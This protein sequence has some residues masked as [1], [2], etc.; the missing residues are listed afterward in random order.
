M[1]S[2]QPVMTRPP[3]LALALALAL[4][5]CSETAT[6]DPADADIDDDIGS[7]DKDRTPDAAPDDDADP[8]VD[9]DTAP[10]EDV[11]VDAGFAID[12]PAPIDTPRDVPVVI[13]VPPPPRD[14]PPPPRDV[15]PPPRDVP[16][17]PPV[18]PMTG[19]L[20]DGTRPMPCADPALFSAANAEGTYYAYCTGM[21]HVWTTSD[22]A[23]FDDRRAATRF[24]LDGMPANGRALGSWWAPGIVYAPDLRR[25]VMWVSVPDARARHT[26]D[27]WDTRSL[28]VLT[29]ATPTGPWDYRNLGLAATANG[30]HFIDPFLFRDRD[31]RRYVFF[32]R[33]GGGVSSSIMGAALDATWQH[34]V[35][36]SQVEV[37]NGYGG[38]GTWEDNVRENPA[39]DYDPATGHHHMLFSGAHWADDSYATGHSLSTCGPLCVRSG[40]GWH[41]VAS[42]DRGIPQVVRAN[43]VAAF[44][45][46]GPGG[47]VFQDDRARFI[48]YAAAARSA[49]GDSTR[50]LMR[51][52]IR[53]RNDAPYVDTAGHRPDP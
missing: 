41:F 4:L 29:S 10:D 22:W 17:P 30:Q 27:G 19:L 48:V 18:S 49:A 38:A 52:A 33:Y 35:A 1:C 7:P 2:N 25:Y 47:A 16:T 45:R 23:R 31:G 50:Y 28:A 3:R 39:V 40:P 36:G 14:L 46:G 11:A 37:M 21:S 44:R 13:D 20:L 26:A 9:E 51:Q 34:V 8:I 6:V 43:G 12:S 24:N 15:P 5:G 53:W 42:G 32:K